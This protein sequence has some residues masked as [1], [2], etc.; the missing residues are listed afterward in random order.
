M[1][2]TTALAIAA[3][4]LIG[5]AGGFAI[6]SATSSA[7]AASDATAVAAADSVAGAS[8]SSNAVARVEVVA[9]IQENLDVVGEA[10]GQPSNS[11]ATDAVRAARGSSYP[12][13]V[14]KVLRCADSQFGGDL[15]CVSE[16]D[17]TAN[18]KFEMQDVVFAKASDGTWKE[19]RPF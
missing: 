14:V 3:S 8:A 16:I 9:F 5:G 1:P 11:E 6:A 12:D 19:M 13:A 2:N 7:S 4:L 17:F 10:L 15:M 18:G